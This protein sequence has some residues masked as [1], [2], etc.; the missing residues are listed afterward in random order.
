MDI[1]TIISDLRASRPKY[2]SSGLVERLIAILNGVTAFKSSGM[3]REAIYTARFGL[4]TVNDLLARDPSNPSI[5]E[6]KQA[7]EEVV[8]LPDVSPNLVT[9]RRPPDAESPT[10]SGPY[11]AKFPV[12]AR[13]RV[14][15]ES[16]LRQFQRYWHWHHPVLDE[17]IRFAGRSSVVTHVGFYH[18]G[19]PLY[20]LADTAEYLW[21][22]ACLGDG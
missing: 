18:G 3:Y 4:E 9:D 22:E 1:K 13:V 15:S 20:S 17:Q 12:G 8:A 10:E 5:T 21:H 2:D 11:C 19:E 16:E 6:A 14:A 7:L